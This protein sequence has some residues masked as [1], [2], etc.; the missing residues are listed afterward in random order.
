MDERKEKIL[1]SKVK[2]FAFMFYALDKGVGDWLDDHW[3][4]QL[5][6]NTPV[7]PEPKKK[8]K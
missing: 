3:L 4:E 2:Q 5:I 7:K 8:K 6:K 1:R